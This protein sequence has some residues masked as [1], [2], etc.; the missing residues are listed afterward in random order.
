MRGEEFVLDRCIHCDLPA[1]EH[2][3]GKC[4]FASS[5]WEPLY[6]TVRVLESGHLR[7]SGPYVEHAQQIIGEVFDQFRGIPDT[8]A[9]RRMLAGEVLQHL[10]NM[11]R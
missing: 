5:Q 10:R 11:A 1:G 4:L 7:V 6:V 8:H 3:R 2:P 9:A